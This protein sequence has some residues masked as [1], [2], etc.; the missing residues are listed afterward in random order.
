M[1]LKVHYRHLVT[2]EGVARRL[3]DALARRLAPLFT[4][5]PCE[6]I[7]RFSSNFHVKRV[8]AKESPK[9]LSLLSSLSVWH[10]ATNINF[11]ELTLISCTAFVVQIKTLK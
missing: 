9:V 5:L 3:F 10:T 8:I 7:L 1:H 6:L 11:G 2:T 4:E